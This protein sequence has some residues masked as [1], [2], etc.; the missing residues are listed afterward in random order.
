MHF[1]EHMKMPLDCQSILRGK[2]LDLK[3]VLVL[4][5]SIPYCTKSSIIV[6]SLKAG[7]FTVST[8]TVFSS[9]AI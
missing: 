3:Y 8:E 1:T 9:D 2:W 5:Y 4:K 6:Y 7:N